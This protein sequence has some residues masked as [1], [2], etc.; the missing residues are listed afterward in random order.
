MKSNA[1]PTGQLIALVLL[2]PP[3]IT[4]IWW[5]MAR[6]WAGMVQGA[7]VSEATKKR[8]RWEFWALLVATYLL[9]FGIALY[10][11]LRRM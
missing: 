10:A 1:L 2:T 4:C 7:S 8:Q 11:W 6:G 3:I 9:V 5:L